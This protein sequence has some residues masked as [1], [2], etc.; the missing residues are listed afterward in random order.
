MLK[1]FLFL[2]ISFFICACNSINNFD[3]EINLFDNNQKKATFDSC[4]NFSYISNVNDIKYGN[5][6]IEYVNLD[7][8]CSWNG[9][10]RGHFEYLFETTLKLKSLKVIE[11]KDFDNYEFTT[12]LVN[13]EYYM[14]LIYKY[15]V[16]EDLFV[17]DYKGKYS[18]EL[19]K[20]YDSNY[21]NLYLNKPRFSS[22][23]SKSLVNMNFINSY[24]SRER[25]MF[26][27]K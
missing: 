1:T 21:E 24:F 17:I 22:N 10:S 6:F 15:S 16:Y 4:T 7:S 18:T 23:Y 27:E 26:F 5:L 14:N 2:V 3:N 13:G 25:D 12:Y 20:K 11:R 9:F 19:I 8:S